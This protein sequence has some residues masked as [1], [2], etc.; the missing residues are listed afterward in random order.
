MKKYALSELVFDFDIYPRGDVDSHHVG[1]IASAIEAG[2]AMPPIVIDLKSKRIADG[3][4]RCRAYRRLY[5]EAHQIDCIEKDYKNDK[6]LF[7]DSM[8]YNAS[9]GRA[10]TQH[11]KV[12]CLLL[13]EKLK[14]SS[15]LVAQALNITTDR[16]GELRTD[17]VGRIGSTPVALK[18]T[19]RH[20]S[21]KRLTQEQVTANDKLSGMNQLFYVN[22]IITLIE[23]DLID[24]S[25]ADLQQGLTKLHGLLG[26]LVK[27]KAA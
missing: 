10:L 17:R 7:L 8:R 3:F 9:H 12:H 6:E 16:V 1:E 11:D 5:G 15:A 27:R 13:A 14:V 18:Q 19:I 25:N 4:H 21:G 26:G 22:Q 23:S 20:M 2:Q 24:T